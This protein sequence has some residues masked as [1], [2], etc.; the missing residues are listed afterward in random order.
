MDL[1]IVVAMA[2]GRLFVGFRREDQR[3]HRHRLHSAI[4]DGRQKAGEQAGL[5]QSPQYAQHGG[6]A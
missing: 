3:R 2:G 6:S 4:D 1:P 5:D